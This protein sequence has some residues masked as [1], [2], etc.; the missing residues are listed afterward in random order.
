M[1]GVL[2]PKVSGAAGL[3]STA[4]NPG[5]VRAQAI[6]DTPND[7]QVIQG[8][9]N[10]I[11]ITV[12]VTMVPPESNQSK[13]SGGALNVSALPTCTVT[14][15]ERTAGQ[16]AI[17]MTVTGPDISG[18]YT[19]TSNA[20]ITFTA[21]GAHTLTAVADFTVSSGSSV[22]SFVIQ[23]KAGG[24]G[25]GGGGGNV[26]PPTLI[27]TSPQDGAVIAAQ[28]GDPNSP[29][30]AVVPFTGSA[31]A[32]AGAVIRSVQIQVGSDA[33]TASNAVP[34]PTAGWS[35][36][37]GS[38]VL[39]GYGAQT[40]TITVKDSNGSQVSK[41]ITL[42]LAPFEPRLWL[43][44]KLVIIEE[45]R[46]TNFAGENGR[47]RVLRTLSLLPGENTTISV[48]SYSTSE[49]TTTNTSS[50]FDELNDSTTSD[51]NSSVADE[52]TDKTSQ[53]DSEAWGIQAKAS[54]SWGWGN[55]E[56]Q[57]SYKSDSNSA[58]EDL[59]KAVASATQKHAAQRSSRRTVQVNAENQQTVTSG[60]TQSIQRT[61]SNINVSRTLNFIFYQLNQEYISLLHLVDVRIGYVSA[62]LSLLDSKTLFDYQE[63]TLTDVPTLIGTAI[64]PEHQAEVVGHIMEV[65]TN[66]V[67]YADVRHT[68]T[69]TV[70]P[71]DE[72]TGAP[73]PEAQYFRFRRNLLGTWT[74]PNTT[75]SYA[76][77]GVIIG[78]TNVTMRTDGVL[79]D[80]AL[81]QNAA[82]DDYNIGLQQAALA[83][84]QLANAAA[85]Q[86]LDLV[87]NPDPAKTD[88]WQKTHPQPLP[89]ELTLAAAA[90]GSGS[91]SGG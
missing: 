47:G 59:R 84:R 54:A 31:T 35:Q 11:Q 36:W 86:V 76:V 17:P 19:A 18:D 12:E 73:V 48:D 25:G 78:A 87:N 42:V 66:V 61:I 53:Q 32:A 81:G 57:G 64:K 24:G 20:P 80:A 85:Q 2:V 45:L 60:T 68:L 49:S 21:S 6:F 14:L 89:A 75:A 7:K 82:I 65:L 28:F 51:F 27:L 13:I 58:R 52:Q 83:Q 40:V 90:A 46:L 29:A 39:T 69:E 37:S 30:E 56:V 79:V 26:D 44:S 3:G 10:A 9:G 88:A 22:I 1:A 63:V 70:V 8:S 62:F 72:V 34:D 71:T 74:D 41:T 15:D 5:L 38:Q 16:Q 55:A 23:L 50:I 91:G 33:A 43:Y 67:D 4:T 77:P